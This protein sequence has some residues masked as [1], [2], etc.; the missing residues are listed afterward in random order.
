MLITFREALMYSGWKGWWL[1][2]RTTQTHTHTNTLG[3]RQKNHNRQTIF[4][5]WTPQQQTRLD[6][7]YAILF[8]RLGKENMEEYMATCRHRA[9]LH[10]GLHA[11]FFHGTRA[12]ITVIHLLIRTTQL[13]PCE[14]VPCTT[15]HPISL[16]SF[17]TSTNQP[18]LP[19]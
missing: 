16:D 5:R 3:E 9:R 10:L 19:N 17:L 11:I 12:T 8:T 15:L 14:P 4:R 13:P 18:G 1:R 7:H 2:P 6:L